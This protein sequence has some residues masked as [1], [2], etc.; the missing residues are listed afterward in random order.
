M[1]TGP[2][3]TYCTTRV[4][5]PASDVI[6]TIDVHCDFSRHVRRTLPDMLFGVFLLRGA[7]C[8]AN[9]DHNRARLYPLCLAN[10][11]IRHLVG[12]RLCFVLYALK[13]DM[14][15]VHFVVYQMARATSA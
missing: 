9:E 3:S 14:L 10:R 12:S 7:F 5:P 11:A 8:R 6:A 15:Y 13:S 1:R 4:E 2:P